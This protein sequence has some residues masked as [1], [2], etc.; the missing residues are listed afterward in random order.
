MSKSLFFTFLLLILPVVHAAGETEKTVLKEYE[1][2][3]IAVALSTTTIPYTNHDAV[4]TS[5][6]VPLI[7]FENQTFFINGLE[8]GYKVLETKEW[9]LS[10]VARIRRFNLPE[11]Y[12][13]LAEDKLDIGGQLRYLPNPDSK[14]D[15]ELM[16]ATGDRFY[17]RIRFEK[18]IQTEILRY[19]RLPQLVLKV[20]IST[21]FSMAWTRNSY[22][23]ASISPWVS[24]A[25]IF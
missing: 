16:R 18:K 8:A 20:M 19:V 1:P 15:I 6:L 14:L 17:G 9:R 5:L 12:D 13:G 7:Y 21:A 22:R 25:A 23:Q 10:T 11:E 4:N 3:G 24:M 2:F